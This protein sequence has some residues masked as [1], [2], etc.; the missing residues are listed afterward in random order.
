MTCNSISI[1]RFKD[2]NTESYLQRIKNIYSNVIFMKI[3]DPENIGILTDLDKQRITLRD[4]KAQ[5]V[6]D[7]HFIKNNEVKRGKAMMAN[8]L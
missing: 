6:G 4:L 8:L 1:R 5:N 3:E 7:F 2:S